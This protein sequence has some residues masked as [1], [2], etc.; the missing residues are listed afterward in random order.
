MVKLIE[1]DD[2]RDAN[3]ALRLINR[4]L[5]KGVTKVELHDTNETN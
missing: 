3:C 2:L 4:D 1:E 5:E